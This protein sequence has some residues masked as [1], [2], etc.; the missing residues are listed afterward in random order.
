MLAWWFDLRKN[1]GDAIN[2]VLIRYLSGETPKN[3]SCRPWRKLKQLITKEPVYF[4]VGS[5]LQWADRYSIIWGAGFISNRWKLRAKPQEIRAVRG[6]LTRK[7]IINQG[8]ECPEIYGDPVLLL[9]RFYYPKIKKKYKLGIIPHYIDKSHP[10]LEN[11]KNISDVLILDIEEDTRK[12]VRDVLSCECI[13]SSALHGLILAD[14]YGIPSTW[15]KLSDKVLGK[16]FKFRDYFASVHR[17]DKEPVI[18]NKHTKIEDILNSFK[19]Y[20][21]DID[22]E[23]LLDSCP[24]YKKIDIN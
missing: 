5:T 7:I 16:G 12:F 14:S 18:L 1:F 17:Q 8:L 10:L 4:V 23:T 2:P 3:V 21:I 6:P 9:P 22:L 24:F 19:N 20:K 13:A 15:I 11:F